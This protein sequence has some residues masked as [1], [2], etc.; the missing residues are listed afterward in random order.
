M[1]AGKIPQKIK[2]FCRPEITITYSR[3]SD[4]GF[5]DTLAEEVKAIP[6]FIVDASNLKTQ[7]TAAD[8][9]GCAQWHWDPVTGKRVDVSKP[10]TVVE[11]DNLPVKSVR[12]IG[13]SI[14]G[15]GGRAYQA[16]VDEKYLVD[17]RED[18]LLDTMLHVGIDVNG[19][20]KG[21]YIF[22]QVNSEMKIIRVNSKLHDLMTEST[23]ISDAKAITNFIP[24]HIYESKTKKALYL[25]EL[26]HV[27]YEETQAYG[28]YAYTC[29]IVQLPPTKCHVFIEMRVSSENTMQDI[30]NKNLKY[31]HITVDIVK[32]SL[33][34]AYKIDHGPAENFEIDEA[35]NIF[36]KNIEDNINP[37]SNILH[38][39]CLN[40]STVPGYIHPKLQQL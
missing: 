1:K 38:Y 9:A 11:A 27:D 23:K 7:K 15:N 8:W 5:K 29:D 12:I 6:T 39:R 37:R 14:R 13:L 36:R 26:W 32:G 31:F 20:L 17:L 4:V 22:A 3:W 10:Y 24:G 19:V 34:K 30:L 18:V 40:L 21:Q 33:S 28:R 2:L 16:L 25:G 35:L